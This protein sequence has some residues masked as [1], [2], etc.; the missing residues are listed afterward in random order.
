[1][2]WA[3]DTQYIPQRFPPCDIYALECNYSE[4]DRYDVGDKEFIKT[5]VEHRKLFPTK[6]FKRLSSFLKAGLVEV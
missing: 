5:I 3:T 4:V 2:L 1:M 6:A